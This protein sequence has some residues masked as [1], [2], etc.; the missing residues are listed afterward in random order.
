LATAAVDY[1]NQNKILLHTRHPILE[2]PLIN[3]PTINTNRSIINA[4][5][6]PLGKG[7][8]YGKKQAGYFF[9]GQRTI[10]TAFNPDDQYTLGQASVGA[11]MFMAPTDETTLSVNG[12]DSLSIKEIQYG[13]NNSV[14]IPL[15]F[16]FRMTD[17]GGV[18]DTGKGFVGGDR[19]GATKDITYA[20]QMGIDIV[21]Y[22]GTNETRFSFDIEIF[23]K[24]RSNKL[25]LGKIPVRDISLAINDIS[26][27]L[28]NTKPNVGVIK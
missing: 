2:T 10:K 23:A 8:T 24:Y 9:D 27:N 6:A 26:K 16:Q 13:P 5:T 19:T 22:D 4:K 18:G 15:V 3:A 20:K 17:Y 11:Y 21:T 1:D 25:N 7:E 28:G 14:Q 12:N